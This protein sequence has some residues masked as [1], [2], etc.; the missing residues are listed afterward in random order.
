MNIDSFLM[1]F[2]KEKNFKDTDNFEKI[3]RFF[4]ELNNSY[5]SG[6]KISTVISYYLFEKI[7]NE[8]IRKRKVSARDFEDFMAMSLNGKIMDNE[9]R[10]NLP[11]PNVRAPDKLILDY[12][13]SNRREK[14]DI[15]FSSNYGVSVKTSLPDNKEINMGSF[16]RE[17]LFKDF[18]TKEEYGG[19]RKSGLGS[20][21]QIKNVFLKIKN[22]KNWEIFCKRFELMVENIFVDDIVFCIKGGSYLTIYFI[23]GDK[24]RKALI[25]S[26]EGGPEHSIDIINR[27]EG[28]SLR[29]D[30]E[31]VINL[32]NKVKIDF[33]KLEKSNIFSIM[34]TI[35]SFENSILELYCGVSTSKNKS[36][37]LKDLNS[38]IDAL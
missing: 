2:K 26:I 14:M 37:I 10:R 5:L 30:R 13:S 17:A 6:D 1:F 19:E 36:L 38:F 32:G 35:Y 16:A 31:K 12:I 20:K 28:N 8:K 3:Y 15:L 33:S 4:N 22:K 34:Q 24:F 9:S 21:P 11:V 27:Y 18:L 7:A 25:E 29:V 23:E